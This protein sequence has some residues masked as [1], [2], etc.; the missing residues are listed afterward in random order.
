MST[1]LESSVYALSNHYLYV[2]SIVN[3]FRRY[4]Q[5]QNRDQVVGTYQLRHRECHIGCNHSVIYQSDP[6]F[7]ENKT[8][9]VLFSI[10]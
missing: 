3:S 4:S 1:P 8:E 2:Y 6:L 9:N 10:Y 7:T 5:S